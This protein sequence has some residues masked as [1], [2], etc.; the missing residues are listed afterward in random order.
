MASVRIVHVSDTHLSPTHAYFAMNWAAFRAGMATS[1]PDFLVHGGDLAFNAPEVEDDLAFAAKAV[2]DLG[3]PWRAIPGNH[4]IGEAPPFSR[5]DQ[6]VTPARIAAWRR[7]VGPQWWSH[8]IGDW[9]LIGLD[10]SLMAS[11]L[12]EEAEQREFFHQALDSRG[13]RPVMMFVHMPPFDRDPEDARRSTSVIPFP[14]RADF[15]DACASG[16]VK[17]IACGHLHVY[18]RHRHR[19][20]DIVWAPPTAMVNVRGGLKRWRRLPRPGYVEWQL[21]GK[22]A[23]HRLVEPERMFVIDTTGWTAGNNTT[24]TT[25]PPWS[26]S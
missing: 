3:L 18:R 2:A 26:G 12:P 1:P 9:R 8:D 5:L 7:H 4:D 14:A 22:R 25:L 13:G 10:T 21:D 16:G 11:D 23:T 20:M 17:V 6:P 19:G 24:T 15:L